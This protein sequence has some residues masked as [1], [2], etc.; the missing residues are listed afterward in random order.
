MWQQNF[1]FDSHFRT[2]VFLREQFTLFTTDE[3]Y[4]A[5]DFRQRYLVK[6]HFGNKQFERMHLNKLV[7]SEGR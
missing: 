4:K 7:L 3:M 6:C 2:S 5:K 1:V